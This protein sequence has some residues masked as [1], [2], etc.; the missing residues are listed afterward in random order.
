[1]DVILQE[2]SHSLQWNINF[3]HLTWN[4]FVINH[5]C[6][7]HRLI[8]LLVKAFAV[9]ILK[10]RSFGSSKILSWIFNLEATFDSQYVQSKYDFGSR[11]LK[12]AVWI[13]NAAA[14]FSHSIVVRKQAEAWLHMLNYGRSGSQ[15]GAMHSTVILAHAQAFTDQGL[16]ICIWLINEFQW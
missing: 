13:W 15:L 12:G 14:A 6:F 1:M 10:S 9:H 8:V 7:R 2:L 4:G 11:G 3:A 5:H 16:P